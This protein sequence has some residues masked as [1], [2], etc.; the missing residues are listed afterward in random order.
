MRIHKHSSDIIETLNK[1]TQEI[2]GVGKDKDLQD[3]YCEFIRSLSDEDLRT[4]NEYLVNMFFIYKIRS[5]ESD[6]YIQ[7]HI[8][9]TELKSRGLEL[10]CRDSLPWVE[11]WM[12]KNIMES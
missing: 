6:H 3:K 11:E 8:A 4:T 2:A 7:A 1:K 10:R 12:I 9:Q 5:F